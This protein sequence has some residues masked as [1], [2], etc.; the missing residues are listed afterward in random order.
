MAVDA[1]RVVVAV[2][3]DGRALTLVEDTVE[4]DDAGSP[5]AF[6]RRWESADG[7]EVV[8]RVT[9]PGV[10]LEAAVHEAA[11]AAAFEAD[12]TAG[13]SKSELRDA[14]RSI[15]QLASTPAGVLVAGG[16]LPTG[17]AVAFDE[18]V[19]TGAQDA[20]ST[21]VVRH[22]RGVEPLLELGGPR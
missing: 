16:S 1:Q 17:L 22:A 15:Y 4:G 21:V 20:M 10:E 6:T 7:V 8:T 3:V 12:L 14:V 2:S 13:L 11:L 18:I 9:A 5:P 19:V